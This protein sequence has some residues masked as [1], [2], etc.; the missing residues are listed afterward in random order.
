MGHVL[1]SGFDRRLER[2]CGAAVEKIDAAIRSLVLE[3]S[4]GDV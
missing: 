4:I 2:V 3:A 1:R